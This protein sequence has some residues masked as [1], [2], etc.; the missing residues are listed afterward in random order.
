MRRKPK[1]SKE[2][3]ELIDILEGNSK[4]GDKNDTGSN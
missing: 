1:L 4:K 2:A 3:Q